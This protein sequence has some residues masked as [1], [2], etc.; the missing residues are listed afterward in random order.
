M[1]NKYKYNEPIN[2]LDNRISAHA[3]F[4]DFNLHN[5]IS[6]KFDI[7][8]GDN[9]LD[10][11]CGN[12]NYTELFFKKVLESGVIYGIDKNKDLIVDANSKYGALSKNIHF[13]VE[14]YDLVDKIDTSFDWIFSIYSLY[15][16][17]NSQALVSK[18]KNTLNYN[19]SFIVIGPASV[20]A[21]DL[22]DFHFKVV[23]VRPNAEHRIR[24]KRIEGE[25][26]PLFKSVFGSNNV[27]LEILDT[28]M[29][30]PTA[31]DYAEYYWSTLL[32]RES[33]DGLDINEIEFLKNKTLSLLSEC[34]EFQIKKQMSCLVGS[35]N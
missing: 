15:Y 30:F 3:S 8:N 11:G 10:I 22:D 5:W 4:S 18:L 34:E 19:G 6:S 26:Y 12:G 27:E 31:Y 24:N 35:K 1:I 14:D 13:Q 32:W 7:K 21:I 20:N 17:S 2:S 25:F 28:R 33:I 9:I 23:G 29:S 16:T